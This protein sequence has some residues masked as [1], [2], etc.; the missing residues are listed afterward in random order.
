LPWRLGC[1][2]RVSLKE[3][4]N[5]SQGRAGEHPLKRQSLTV[6]FQAYK[7]TQLAGIAFDCIASVF[8]RL[9]LIATWL[10]VSL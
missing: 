2:G 5:Q 3:Q 9:V 7:V 8:L 1:F 10:V 6:L 4:Y